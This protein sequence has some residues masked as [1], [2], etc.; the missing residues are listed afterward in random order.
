MNVF[1][2]KAVDGGHD[3]LIVNNI[4]D[5]DGNLATQF[6]VFKPGQIKSATGNTGQFSTTTNNIRYSKTSPEAQAEQPVTGLKG[7]PASLESIQREAKGFL[8]KYSAIYTDSDTIDTSVWDRIFQSPEYYFKKVAALGR[9]MKAAFGRRDLR[10]NY[11][12]QILGKEFIKFAEGLKE[13]DAKAYTDANDYLVDTDQTGYAF[14]MKQVNDSWQVYNPKKDVIGSFEK[15]SDAKN[16]MMQAEHDRLLEEGYSANAAKAVLLARQV[17]NTEFDVRA[18]DMR[19]IQEEYKANGFPDPFISDGAIDEAGRYG[20]YADGKKKPIALFATQKEADEFLDRAAQMISYMA[21]SKS[22][23][24]QNDPGAIGDGVSREFTSEQKAKKWA[25]K[26]GGTVKGQKRFGTLTVKKRTDG[27]MRPLALSQAIA[28]M[29]DLRGSYFPRIRNAGEYVLIARK[30]G[31]NPRREHFDLPV[32][33]AKWGSKGAAANWTMANIGRVFPNAARRMQELKAQGYTVEF[34]KDD[35]PVE[36]VFDAS[37]LIA[38]IDAIIADNL[39][40]I[41]K[42]DSDEVRAALH[43]DSLLTMQIAD[44]FKGRGALSSRM[45][46]LAGDTVWE[47]YEPDMLK[48]I[49]QSARDTAAGLA[50]R[51]TSKAML[52]AFTGRDF[53]WQDYKAQ[54]T[55]EGERPS[56]TEYMEIIDDRRVHP[57]K[58]KNAYR[59][60]RAFMVD[61]LRNSEHADRII[62]T[63]QGLAVLKFLGF[64]VSSAAVNLTNMVTGVPGTISGLTGES[65]TQ[66]MGRVTN[67]AAAYGKYRKETREWMPGDTNLSVDDRRAF[68]YIVDNGW[69]EAQ[70]HHEAAGVLM[71]KGSEMW[72]KFTAASMFMF[73]AVEKVN[74]ATTT[75]AAY[76]AIMAKNPGKSFETAMDEAHEVSNRAHGVYGKETLPAWARGKMNPLRLTYTFQK[77]THNYMMNMVGLAWNEKQYKAALYLLLSPAILGGAGASLAGPALFALAGVLGFGGDD[78]EEEFYKLAADTFGSDTAARHGLAGLAGVNIKGSLGVH[79]PMPTD[80]SRITP[81]ELAGPAGGVIKDVVKSFGHFGKGEVAK[82]AE[83]LLP[84]AFGS[85]FKALREGREGVSTGNYGQ[86]FY[87]NEPLKADTLASVLR[88]FSFN[89]SRLSGIREKQWNEKEVAAKYQERKSEIYSELKRLHMQG[90]PYLTPETLKEIKRYNDLVRGSGRADI[91]PITQQRIRLMMRRNSKASKFERSRARDMAMNE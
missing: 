54:K 29:G 86:V 20:V 69:D 11:E 68:Q 2:K 66:A 22:K 1:V 38:S 10:F 67:A 62:G 9:V 41:N 91:K 23:K 37:K 90:K 17:L 51:D 73:G 18:A 40:K 3:S 24:A 46:R 45:K 32:A 77:F 56:F 12:H 79:M 61:V 4:V 82:G 78:P 27:E 89:P 60:G 65:I 35:S 28:Q 80:I 83:A 47:G 21:I 36:D 6:I 13:T 26:H 74:R 81:Y 49:V 5:F 34:K 43:V 14:R 19:R 53:S 75:F 48:A 84:T 58:Q 71:S 55:E 50:K 85:G 16:A 57:G 42:N 76:N 87:G 59:D 31:M 70:F 30:H 88:F 7:H 33:G 64:R 44:T 72:N 52:N 8:D 39:S 15:E 63:L 25:A